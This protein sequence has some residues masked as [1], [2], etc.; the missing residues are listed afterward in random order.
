MTPSRRIGG[1]PRGAWRLTRR[2]LGWLDESWR[3]LIVA[4]AV[5]A[6][7]ALAVEAFRRV[8]FA[9]EFAFVGAQGG[10]LVAAAQHLDPEARLLAPAIGGFAAGLLLWL[11]ARNAGAAA[12]A[13]GGD[14]IEAVAVGSGLLD[15]RGGLRKVI[16]SLLVVAT[17]GAVGRE[18]AMVL[19][20]A[21]LASLLGRRLGRTIELR[22]V[23]SCGAAAGLAAAYHA[24]LASAMFVAEILLGSLALS[25]FGPVA[26]A[27][28]LSYGLTTAIHGPLPPFALAPLPQPGWRQVAWLL[29]LG[30]LGGLAGAGFLRWLGF[31]RSWF[32]RR[33]LPPPLAFAL[34]GLVV[35]LLSLWRPE[36]WG[37]GYSTIERLLGQPLGWRVVALV[38]VLKT[39]A[40]GA[41][42]GSGAPGG[43]FTP[44]LFVGAAFGALFAASLQA[45]GV[46][47]VFEPVYALLGMASLLAATTRAPVMAAL[48]VFEMTG[49][50]H[51]LA[52]LLPACVVATLLSRRLHPESVYG[53]RQTV[54]P[55]GRRIRHPASAASSHPAAADAIG[56]T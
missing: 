53:L 18:G 6:L 12:P 22:L 20:A 9:L 28:V 44:T 54:A 14:Y 38:L 33:A 32:A 35:G 37:N 24:P 8:L 46:T 11:A 50:Y 45:L 26:V 39:V 29:P 27:A 51:L 47:Q 7:G 13:H 21:M 55:A 42:T 17:G 16:A 36:V 31:A 34:G 48:M 52:V 2:R 3:S 19:T 40:V 15:L 43:V 49:Q 41:T 23:V 5:G 1:L 30:L 4:V 56:K 10:H 25:Q